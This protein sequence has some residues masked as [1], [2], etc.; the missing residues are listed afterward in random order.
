M[1]YLLK[2]FKM[3]RILL[4]LVCL[5]TI[6]LGQLTYIP[7]DN[8]EQAL[9]ELGYDEN[10]DDYV[11]TS[12]IENI[13][14]LS[15]INIYDLTGLEDFISLTN[16]SLS[17]L[18]LQE[19][20]INLNNS[21]NLD[22]LTISNVSAHSL[23]MDNCSEIKFLTMED[24]DFNGSP[25]LL[26]ND[27][28][29]NFINLKTLFLDGPYI[30]DFDLSYNILLEDLRYVS[31]ENGGQDGSTS[32]DI[33]NLSNLR[34]LDLNFPYYCTGPEEYWQLYSTD[35]IFGNHPYLES[36]SFNSTNFQG[37]FDFNNCCP[38]L[39]GFNHAVNKS[40]WTVDFGNFESLELI[41]YIQFFPLSNVTFSKLDFSEASLLKAF[42][43][44]SHNPQF[45]TNETNKIDTLILS[46]NYFL[47]TIIVD[48]ADVKYIDIRNGNNESLLVS[49]TA[50][51]GI[52]IT[53]PDFTG[54][55]N[56]NCVNVDNFEYA[57]LN[58]S[59]IDD[60]S[61]Y[62]ENCFGDYPVTFNCINN[63]CVDPMDGSGEYVAYAQCNNMCNPQISFDCINDA[64]VDPLDGSGEF[65]TLNECEQACENI[66]SINENI[67]DVNIYPNPSSN[68]FNLEFNLDSETDIIVT[69]IL[70]EQVY[71]ESIKSIGEFNTQIDLSNF[72]KG[73]YNLNIKTIEGITNQKL[74]L[75]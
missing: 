69:N 56:L 2:I 43:F 38:N 32:I 24:L 75:Q 54:N 41:E 10:L 12:Q 57:F 66:S 17:S 18:F 37:I 62:S 61:V 34:N 63:S 36:I 22:T 33:S 49:Y 40:E 68:I 11:L 50:E 29:H 70:G 25:L 65:S 31:F 60:V 15:L 19:D 48:N 45:G 47:E 53:H 39:K 42:R 58:W 51:M 72:S 7:D 8:F 44:S 28:F 5:P 23:F 52:E 59:G 30:P 55:P 74:I 26:E 35:V 6:V 71:F 1:I 73:I 21:I 64:C 14:T 13:E 46:N 4:L 3:K 20:T 27:F 67:I 16:L 9:I